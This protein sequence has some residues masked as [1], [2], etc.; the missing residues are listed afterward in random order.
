MSSTNRGSRVTTVR[1]PTSLADDGS[2]LSTLP[3]PPARALHTPCVGG[4]AGEDEQYETLAASLSHGRE[5]DALTACNSN[6]WSSV[7]HPAP[8]DRTEC[9]DYS[10]FQSKA[11]DARN[12]RDCATLTY[13][14]TT[15]GL[16]KAATEATDVSAPQWYKT[17]IP[18]YVRT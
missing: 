15:C 2:D 7:C 9:T 10:E 6:L 5:C 17:L 18:P 14:T 4:A 16:S 1:V 12:N 8:S 11:A 3:L 13:A